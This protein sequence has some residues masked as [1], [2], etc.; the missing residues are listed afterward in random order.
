MDLREIEWE[1]MDWIYLD[2]DRGQ[3]RAVANTVMNIRVLERTGNF[4]KRGMT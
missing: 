2:Q 3:W 1:G 4:L